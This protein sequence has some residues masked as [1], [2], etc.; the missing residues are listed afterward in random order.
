MNAKRASKWMTLLLATVLC[1]IITLVGCA[2]QPQEV[3]TEQPLVQKKA[4][5]TQEGSV[6]G[7]EEQQQADT[8]AKE[9]LA[10]AAQYEPAVTQELQAHEDD[11]AKLVSLDHRFKS[12]ESLARKILLNAHAEEISL[13]EAAEGITDALRYTM[14]IEPPVY[15]SKATEVLRSLEGKGYTVVRFRNKWDGDTYKGLNTLLKYP[16][17]IVFELQFHTPESF[18]VYN[19]THK[20]Y[21]IARAEDSTKEQVE[22]ATRIRRELNEGLTI[23]EGALEFTWE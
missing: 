6:A 4:D 23:P 20:Y 12:Q 7:E 1:A 2:Q 17:G 19:E 13:E 9:R 21:E 5:S 18:E 8:L 14:C 15:V 11:Q 3:T 10:D 16:D 22:E